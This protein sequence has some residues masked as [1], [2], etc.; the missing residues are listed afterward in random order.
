M[1]RQNGLLK[2]KGTLDNVT[3]YKSQDGFMAKM[4]TSLDGERIKNDPSFARTRENGEE[5]GNSASAGK[6]FRDSLRS[7]S[8]GVT[9]KRLVARVTQLMSQIKNED[10]TSARGKRNVAVGVGTAPGKTKLASFE[11]NLNAILG[12]IFLKPFTLSNTTG[13]ITIA[14]IA[15]ANDF[16][17]PTGATHVSL[18]SAYANVNFATGVYD[19]RLSNTVNLAK[20]ATPSTTNT[21]LTP[22]TG[23]TGTGV[24]IFLLKLEFFQEVNGVQYTMKNGSYNALKIVGVA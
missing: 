13:A 20:T 11:F 12:S 4:K 15:P 19:I 7:I 16:V 1:A 18:T 23:I 9:D 24:K 22:A 3:F 2:I 17:W 6:L 14:G 5:F 10:I 8:S 21:V